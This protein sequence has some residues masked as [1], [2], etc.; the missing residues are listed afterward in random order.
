MSREFL[1]DLRPDPV[2]PFADVLNVTNFFLHTS[3]GDIEKGWDSRNH[4]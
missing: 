2:S 4:F 3:L 1:L